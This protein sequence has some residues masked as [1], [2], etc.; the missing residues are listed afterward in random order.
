MNAPMP[1]HRFRIPE[2]AAFIDGIEEPFLLRFCAISICTLARPS[3]VLQLRRS[4]FHSDSNRVMFKRVKGMYRTVPASPT[5]VKWLDKP[6]A[7]GDYYLTQT[8]EPL[9]S[10]RLGA[11]WRKSLKRSGIERKIM[12]FSIRYGMA[13]QLRTQHV[14]L[15][16]IAA[17]LG[18]T[19]P[20]GTTVLEPVH[21]QR[22]QNAIT[23]IE[24]VIEAVKAQLKTVSLEP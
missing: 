17:M 21:P 9:A 18:Y 15:E 6:L 2:I 10:H 20:A 24:R 4:D 16:E 3:E 12:P 23:A 14:A 13:T 5:L 1:K 22:L 19:A 7:H 8:P 11:A